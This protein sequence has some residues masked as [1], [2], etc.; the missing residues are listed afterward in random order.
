MICDRS[1]VT[2]TPARPRLAPG[3]QAPSPPPPRR[4]EVRAHFAAPAARNDSLFMRQRYSPSQ[5]STGLTTHRPVQVVGMDPAPAR[6]EMAATV[7]VGGDACPRYSAPL[8][9][10]A[11]GASLRV[12]RPRRS[13]PWADLIVARRQNGNSSTKAARRSHGGQIRLRVQQGESEAQR[14]RASMGCC[15]RPPPPC[16][17]LREAAARH[18]GGHVS[19][20]RAEGGAR[21]ARP[22]RGLR[23]P[24]YRLGMGRPSRLLRA[25]A[26]DVAVLAAPVALG[27][28]VLELALSG[29]V[30][31]LAAVEAARVPR[32]R[33]GLHVLR[34][35]VRGLGAVP[36]EV[37]GALAVPADLG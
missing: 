4:P 27:A 12:T 35:F 5:P 24:G 14:A 11:P 8:A 18:E 37:V 16:A 32:P 23:C 17:R 36:A 22:A 20:L 25:I 2:D 34:V 6:P 29:D 26:A 33:A 7:V 19:D 28:H 9:P 1:N 31:R 30:A 3:A 10:L 15:R 21:A 13:A